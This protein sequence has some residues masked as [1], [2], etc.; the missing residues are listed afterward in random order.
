M[1]HEQCLC[2][3]PTLLFSQSIT[4]FFILCATTAP[5]RYHNYPHAAPSSPPRADLEKTWKKKK[6]HINRCEE[7]NPISF[8]LIYSVYYFKTKLHAWLIIKIT[9]KKKNLDYYYYF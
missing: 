9:K 4:R 5:R 3:K 2:K 7:S 6:S 8:T 1:I